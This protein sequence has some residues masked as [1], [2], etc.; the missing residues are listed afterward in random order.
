[1]YKDVLVRRLTCNRFDHLYTSRAHVSKC[2]NA[3]IVIISTTL[4]YS[5]AAFIHFGTKLEYRVDDHFG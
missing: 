2:E 3:F 4:P 1:M 5:L